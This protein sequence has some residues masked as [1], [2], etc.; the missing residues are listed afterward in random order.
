M[1]MQVFTVRPVAL[2][3]NFSRRSTTGTTLPRRLIT[4][5]MNSGIRGTRVIAV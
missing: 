4:P 5:R 2:I 3:P 1:M